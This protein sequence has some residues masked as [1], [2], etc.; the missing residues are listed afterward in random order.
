MNQ[1]F[2]GLLLFV[3]LLIPPVASFMESI[4]IIHMHM[5]MPMLVI[6]GFLMAQFILKLFQRFFEKWNS[7]GVPGILLFVI[8]MVYWMLPRTMDEALTVPAVEVFKFISLPFLAGVP[9]RDS[10][11]K[12]SSKGKTTII[13]LF[14]LLFIGVGALYIWSPVQ[15]CNNYLVMEQLTLG[16]GFMTTAICMIIYLVYTYFVDPSEYV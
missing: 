3:F 16:W 15:L 1:S 13:I 4:M 2:Y 11:K 12:L 6:S 8:I 5:Q 10:W 9:L 14:T 7:N